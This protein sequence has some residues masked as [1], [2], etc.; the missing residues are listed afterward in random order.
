MQN[1]IYEAVIIE[2]EGESRQSR[3]YFSSQIFTLLLLGWA[4][5][6]TGIILPQPATACTTGLATGAVTKD[7]RPLLW[8]NRD[9]SQRNN[10]VAYFE[11]GSFRY[12]GIINADDTTQ[13]WAGINN[14]GFAIMNAEARDMAIPGENT[15]YD[16]EGYLMKT[17][18]SRCKTVDDFENLLIQTNQ[19]GRGVTSNF[20]VID[21]YG[22]A[23][24]FE[25]GNH[26]YFRID[27]SDTTENFLIRANFAV[28]AHSDEGYGRQRYLRAR[29]LFREGIAKNRLTPE[30]IL[31]EI[32]GDIQLPDTVRNDL[33]PTSA[34]IQ[35]QQTVNRYRTVSCAVFQ[36]AGPRHPAYLATFWCTLG[37]PVVSISIP[38]WVYAGWV[39]S[40]LDSTGIAPLNRL[41]Q[42]LKEYVYQSPQALSRE[43]IVRLRP[44]LLKIQR[45]IFRQTRKI[46]KQ[47]SRRIPSPHEVAAF[48][49]RMAQMVYSETQ[50]ILSELQQ[51]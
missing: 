39:P 31:R 19:S 27:A 37:E 16:D 42:A 28:N 34:T 44:R 49:A 26:E 7:K 51:K 29:N 18:L 41:F 48:Q 35:T 40:I 5:L 33:N 2:S 9:S 11:A 1:E 32:A 23:S 6:I 8:K 15:A 24:F 30:Y 12:L 3:G 43:R 13:V 17:A 20:G 14:H 22:N 36:G 10:E 46:Q 47:W 45:S 4:L 21:A 38:L 50:Q 25:T